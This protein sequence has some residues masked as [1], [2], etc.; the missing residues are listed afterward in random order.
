MNTSALE[1]TE[2]LHS[3]ATALLWNRFTPVAFLGSPMFK[4]KGE[5]TEKEHNT[6]KS[7]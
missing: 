6:R 7:I 4:R 2:H 3:G 5:V 1:R